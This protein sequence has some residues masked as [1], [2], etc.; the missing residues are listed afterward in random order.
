MVRKSFSLLKGP[1][2]SSHNPDPSED[3]SQIS[4]FQKYPTHPMA[5]QRTSQR[6]VTHIL[7]FSKWDMPYP[8]GSET[9]CPKSLVAKMGCQTPHTLS[10]R[11]TTPSY[12]LVETSHFPCR[13]RP[14]S[15]HRLVTGCILT[16]CSAARSILYFLLLQDKDS[17]FPLLLPGHLM[18]FSFLESTRWSVPH[19]LT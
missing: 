7:L 15:P 11:C 14:L 9:R 5:H 8:L 18:P 12:S 13:G 1:S 16:V 3:I 19:H 10:E 4:R 17:H 6:G 2:P